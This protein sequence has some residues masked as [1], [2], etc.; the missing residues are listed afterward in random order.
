MCHRS[1]GLLQ[2]A[3]EGFGITTVSMTVNPRITWGVRVPR[4]GYLRFPQGNVF[5]LPFDSALQMD[6]LNAALQI[7][8]EA[9]H[10]ESIYELPFRW[11]RPHR[12]EI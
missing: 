4:A 5:G 11:R 12:T 7:A 2:N 1:V 9:M 8:A 10:S 6:V 3:I